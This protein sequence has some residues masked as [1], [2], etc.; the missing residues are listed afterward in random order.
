MN[1]LKNIWIIATMLTVNT[2][3]H[4]IT[5]KL[6][7]CSNYV[8]FTYTRNMKF[9]DAF[10]VE[11]K[12]ID[13]FV[14]DA[15]DRF[16]TCISRQAPF[17][18]SGKMELPLPSGKY[19]LIVW[20]G[21]YESSY[22]FK[23]ELVKGV[24]TPDELTVK[25]QREYV[26]G[27]SGVANM[28]KELDALWHAEAYVELTDSQS[29][30]ITMDLTKNTNK[31]RLVVQMHDG[32][33]LIS[34][35][36]E[37]SITGRNGFLNFDNSLLPD[38]TVI[39]RPYYFQNVTFQEDTDEDGISA[40]VTEM[41][42]LRLVEHEK[43]RLQISRKDGEKLVDI[44]LI[45]YLLLTKMEGHQLPVQE[46]LDRQD[47]YAMIFWLAIDGKG[48]YMIMQIKINDWILRPQDAD[49]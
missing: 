28:N 49:L 7:P 17:E 19:H 43:M 1:V 42:T 13:L 41:N 11:V 36:L 40:A 10:P 25:M 37:F 12:K 30:H 21:L 26:D 8:S 4:T 44:D 47:E 46:Y 14:F 15:E 39:Y 9:V 29:R 33:P 6:Q 23:K 32:S 34:D 16:I 35:D 20:A 31:M 5:E 38:S 48:N 3:C 18:E 45:Q 27:E 22:L 24:S 2:A